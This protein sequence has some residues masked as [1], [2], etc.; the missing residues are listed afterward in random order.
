MFGRR[1]QALAG[2]PSLAQVHTLMSAAREGLSVTI[3]N[4]L[5]FLS[6]FSL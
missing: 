5:C 3:Y 4:F 2:F 1:L 6:I